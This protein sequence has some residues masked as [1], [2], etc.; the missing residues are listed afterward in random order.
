MERTRGENLFS[1]GWNTFFSFSFEETETERSERP[2]LASVV[3]PP[4]CEVDRSCKMH[5]RHGR[6]ECTG[7]HRVVRKSNMLAEIVYAVIYL[8]VACGFSQAVSEF[9]Q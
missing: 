9:E 7:I 5:G 2:R 3:V 6:S 4:L 1:Q 8:V